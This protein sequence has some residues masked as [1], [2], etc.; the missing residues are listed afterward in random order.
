VVAVA[1]ALGLPDR[2]TRSWPDMQT[3][4]DGRTAKGKG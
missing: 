4:L 2:V 3:W 1:D